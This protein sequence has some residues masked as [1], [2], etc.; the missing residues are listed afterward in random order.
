MKPQIALAVLSITSACF[1]TVLAKSVLAADQNPV[2]PTVFISQ[3]TEAQP[4]TQAKKL[5]EWEKQLFQEV[6]LSEEL[7]AQSSGTCTQYNGCS[8]TD[9]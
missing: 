2:Q 8:D 9:C 3:I 6:G 1:T 4:S 5:Q 7:I